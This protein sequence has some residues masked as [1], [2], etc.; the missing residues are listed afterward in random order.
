MIDNF[1]SMVVGIVKGVLSFRNG[2]DQRFMSQYYGYS[3]ATGTIILTHA[4]IYK[5]LGVISLA[6]SW[7]LGARAGV[8]CYSI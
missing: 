6:G 3:H 5:G 8:V 1:Y 7:E 4:N 2:P